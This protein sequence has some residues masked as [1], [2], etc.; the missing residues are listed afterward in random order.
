MEEVFLSSL[1][2]TNKVRNTVIFIRVNCTYCKHKVYPQ[3]VFRQTTAPRD[4]TVRVYFHESAA[5]VQQGAEANKLLCSVVPHHLAL[6]C[7]G[8]SN[9]RSILCLQSREV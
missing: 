4:K 7:V 2:E 8:Q 6:H 5:L 9:K 3:A 1:C